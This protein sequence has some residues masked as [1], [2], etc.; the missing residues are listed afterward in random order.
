MLALRSAP[1]SAR[2]NASDHSAFYAASP[3]QPRSRQQHF[4][5]ST[6]ASVS[7]LVSP[8]AGPAARPASSMSSSF[9]STS[10]NTASPDVSS[11]AGGRSNF[12]GSALLGG[13]IGCAPSPGD[14]RRLR[15][16]MEQE[17]RDEATRKQAQERRQIAK[18]VAL[19]QQQP[20]AAPSRFFDG[21]LAAVAADAGTVA[22]HSRFP[23]ALGS[24][25]FIPHA[26]ARV[27]LMQDAMHEAEEQ[28]GS[29]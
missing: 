19:Q 4:T 14:R 11:G 12:L 1:T 29:K 15:Q 16:A 8:V 22:Y 20:P 26:A 2:S 24:T 18:G 3:A 27:Y 13:F 6:S 28:R 9:A 5:S 25:A 7:A 17:A 21:S 23:F 10:S